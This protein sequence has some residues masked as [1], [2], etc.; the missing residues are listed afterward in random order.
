[1]NRIKCTNCSLLNFASS[2]HC[3]RCNASLLHSN[4]NFQ[5]QPQYTANENG[6]S[7]PVYNIP[8]LPNA[9]PTS[10]YQQPVDT[11]DSTNSIPISG[12]IGLL[13]AYLILLLIF[14]IFSFAST[15]KRSYDPEMNVFTDA[16]SP[17]FYSNFD[18]LIRFE[19][20]FTVFIITFSITLLMLFF[21]KS[22]TFLFWARVF[23][24]IVVICLVIDIYWGHQFFTFVI[25]ELSSLSSIRNQSKEIAAKLVF[26]END[27]KDEY[28]WLLIKSLIT[29]TFTLLWF[30]YLTMSRRVKEIFGNEKP[31]EGLFFQER[32]APVNEPPI[33][34]SHAQNGIVSYQ[35]HERVS[36]QTVSDTRS[37]TQMPEGQRYQYGDYESDTKIEGR[38][39][40]GF[41]MIFVVY[42]VLLAMRTGNTIVHF[43]TYTPP[44]GLK[45][46]ED[47]SSYL[48]YY[49]F[50]IKF[51]ISQ[52]IFLVLLFSFS[53]TIFIL[54][55]FR[56]DSLR[57]TAITLLSLIF[58]ERCYLLSSD[59]I[60]S[61]KH[62]LYI[63]NRD[64]SPYFFEMTVYADMVIAIIFIL[65][66]SLSNRVRDTFIHE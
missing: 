26:R 22:S 50:D 14:A 57:F 48:A 43:F 19:V 62:F 34:P 11:K 55:R 20:S 13:P 60:E 25:N 3:K 10:S 61:F 44:T 63:N 28:K 56:R 18:L 24:T 21:K 40:G 37:F 41:L 30:F 29:L 54:L 52:L 17:F 65:Y 46:E 53:I 23:F 42:L 64:V 47:L 49:C 39:I 33:Q 66:F 1:M 32:V 36:Y 2:T 4:N 7:P 6:A 45:A 15:L 8:P 9:Y 35:T 31:Y 58:L 12:F 16:D 51:G 5:S 59:Y 38:P 27:A